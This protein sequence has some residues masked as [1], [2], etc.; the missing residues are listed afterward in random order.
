MALCLL[1]T[2]KL[3]CVWVEWDA[4][5]ILG[6]STHSLFLFQAVRPMQD[7]CSISCS[8]KPFWEGRLSLHRI[9][10]CIFFYLMESAPSVIGKIMWKKGTSWT[11]HF[12]FR[13]LTRH[14][15]PISI[16]AEAFLP[17]QLYMLICSIASKFHDNQLKCPASSIVFLFF[18]FTSFD[19]FVPI[20][21]PT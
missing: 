9:V 18:S 1:F 13:L 3:E 11:Q 8:K 20:E 21:Q 12:D 16:V 10:P 6:S 14:Q 19:L 4:L 7:M 2:H 17:R 15:Y 5:R